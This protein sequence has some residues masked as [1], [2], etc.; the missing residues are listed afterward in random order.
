MYSTQSILGSKLVHHIR[1][2]E[3]SGQL[4][5]RHPCHRTCGQC[6]VEALQFRGNYFDRA[7]SHA[8]AFPLYH[9]MVNLLCLVPS[10]GLPEIRF[11]FMQKGFELQVVTF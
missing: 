9:S 11:R 3:A 7:A 2:S 8:L 10:K 5:F 4:S 6:F 1:A